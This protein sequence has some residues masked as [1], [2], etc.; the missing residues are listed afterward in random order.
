MISII[1]TYR[2][3]RE[4]FE[5]RLDLGELRD[6]IYIIGDTFEIVKNGY[7]ISGNQRMDWTFKEDY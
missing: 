2:Y 1:D 7:N 4:K 3:D 5:E 6:S